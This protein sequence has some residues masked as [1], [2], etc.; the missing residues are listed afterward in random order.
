MRK[1]QTTEDAKCL[2]WFSGRHVDNCVHTRKG[3]ISKLGSSSSFQAIFQHSVLTGYLE[4]NKEKWY[5]F[6][7]TR[8]DKVFVP[9]LPRDLVE[10]RRRIINEFV[11]FARNM[12][13]R[14]WTVME[15]R[16]DICLVTKDA[17]IGSL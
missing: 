2:M 3:N 8:W 13:I 1:P 4:K 5:I 12:M 17:H 14:V 7:R 6:F 10:L 11:A 9:P 15:Y 16:L